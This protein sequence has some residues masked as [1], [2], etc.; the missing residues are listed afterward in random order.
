MGK[1]EEESVIEATIEVKTDDK[2]RNTAKRKAKS[3]MNS[4]RRE[5]ERDQ[6]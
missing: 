2:K 3:S 4:G 1:E 6:K 5:R